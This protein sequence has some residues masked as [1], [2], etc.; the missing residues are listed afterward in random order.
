MLWRRVRR[1]YVKE[2]VHY[3]FGDAHDDKEAVL[4]GAKQNYVCGRSCAISSLASGDK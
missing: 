2:V 3:I 1:L 4:S